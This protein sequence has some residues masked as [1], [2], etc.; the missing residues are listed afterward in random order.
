MTVRH[1]AYCGEDWTPP[2]G[3][4]LRWHD[5]PAAQ[6]ARHEKQRKRV[7]E[8]RALH[9]DYQARHKTTGVHQDCGDGPNRCRICKKP[10]WNHYYC[11]D[12]W[13]LIEDTPDMVVD[14][15]GQELGSVW[16]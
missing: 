7:L 9:P 10:T 4:G 15:L 13:A 12:C 6:A 1:C 14:C 5:C 16:L 11:S 3:G 2:H 8:W